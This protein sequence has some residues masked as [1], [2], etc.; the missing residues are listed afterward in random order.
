[1][2]QSSGVVDIPSEPRTADRAAGPWRIAVA[3]VAALAAG[4]AVVGLSMGGPRATYTGRLSARILPVTATQDG[5]LTKWMVVEGEPIRIG[6]VMAAISNPSLTDQ[7]RQL[8]QEVARFKVDLDRAL[9][10][11]ELD[12]EWR[13][14]EV[15]AEIF[16]ARLQSA[17]L[18]EEKYRHEMEKV[19]LTDVLTSKSLALWV[20]NDSVFDSVIMQDS[21]NQHGRLSTVLRVEAASNSVDVCSVQVEMCEEQVSSLEQLRESLPERVRRSIGVDI[22]ERQLADAEERLAVLS[23]REQELLVASEVIGQVGVFLKNPGDYVRTGDRIVEIFDDV[24]RHIVVD[25][26]SAAA[27]EFKVGN[28]LPLTFPGNVKRTCRVAKVAPQ[29]VSASESSGDAVVRVR[30]EPAGLL[31][32]H[33]AIGSQVAV[34]LP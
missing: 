18:L 22:V 19:A 5:I 11:A 25:V 21:E 26:P 23:E 31:W 1:M 4:V 10:Q 24:Q 12:L 8:Q 20:P 32:P 27:G 17:E 3:S 6:H 14:K 16:S 30:L 13:V 29:A 15:N 33:V 7:K 2:L 9:A 34:G 28:E